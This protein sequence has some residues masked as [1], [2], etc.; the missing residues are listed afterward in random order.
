MKLRN[1]AVSLVALA[2]A[3][4]AIP[5]LADEDHRGHR[6]EGRRGGE[7][8]FHGHIER[9][10]EHDWDLWRGGRWVHDH[11]DGRLGWWWLAGGLWY[12]YP[13]PV[14]PYP[15]PYQPPVYVT[16]PVAPAMPASPPPPPQPRVWYFC[17]S[18]NA[19]Y[20]YTPSCPEGWRTVPAT[21]QR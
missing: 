21:P 16:P 15:D 20:P 10:H 5:S 12:F 4:T 3:A 8:E 18:S 2:F 11:H 9:F 6:D 13:Q 1:L 14:Y 17:A 19:Y 7:H